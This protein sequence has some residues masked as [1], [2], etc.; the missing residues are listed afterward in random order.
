LLLSQILIAA[1]AADEPIGSDTLTATM[2]GEADEPDNGGSVSGG[3]AGDPVPA[4]A[5]PRP[6]AAHPALPASITTVLPP[7]RRHTRR[8]FLGAIAAVVAGAGGGVAAAFTRRQ[9]RPVVHPAP[10][11]LLDA[12]A[13]EQQLTRSAV[14][15]ARAEPA[16]RARLLQLRRDHEAHAAAL[17]AQLA[18]FAKPSRAARRRAAARA[19]AVA[20]TSAAMAA[21]EGRAATAAS[22]RAVRL[23]V[24]DPVTATVLATISA[25]EAGHVQL[26]R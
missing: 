10:Q 6:P 26:L 13:A 2:R 16:A 7:Q 15:T 19:R 4:D 9:P 1:V 11:L 20:T 14:L 3:G 17:R 12:Y 24:S 18:P 23:A 21:A 8:W 25:C 5:A 22:A